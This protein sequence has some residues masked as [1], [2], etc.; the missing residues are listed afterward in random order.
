M[1][2]PPLTEFDRHFRRLA[3]DVKPRLGFTRREAVHFSEWQNRTR[4]AV[5]RQLKMPHDPA[6]LLGV[7]TLGAEDAGDHIRERVRLRT[8]SDLWVPAYVL[9]PKRGGAR[10]R[11]AVLALHGHGPGKRV[12]A[13]LEPVVNGERDY[14]VQAV[15]NGCVALVPDMRGFGELMAAHDQA[16]P[17]ATQSCLILTAWANMLGFTA[18]GM[19]IH[20]LRCCLD[21]LE[22]RPD[23]EPRRLWAVGHSG[24]GMAAVFLAAIDARVS[25]TVCSGYACLW[26]H[27]LMDMDHCSCNF[28]PGLL[29]L[30]EMP[31][32]LGLIAPRPLLLVAGRQDPLF[33][34][35][36]VKMAYARARA[37]YAAA[38]APEG[39]ELVVGPAGHRFYAARVWPWLRE[40]KP[41]K[42]KP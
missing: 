25:A 41:G 35:P 2:R 11:P 12:P 7:E 27:S 31:D 3:R 17:R 1:P 42:P 36:G 10:R 33:P 15:R 18:M 40:Q 9:R 37:M 5:V 14:G 38:G 24:G 16:D 32:L 39:V 4:A 23:V 8:E 20:D 6:R 21:Y 22:T 29:T 19:R 34:L 13:G 30:I 28:V 26:R